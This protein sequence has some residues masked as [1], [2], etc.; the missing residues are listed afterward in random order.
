MIQKKFSA[1]ELEKI[2]NDYKLLSLP[3]GERGILGKATREGW[4]YEQVPSK[5]GKGG[6]KKVFLLPNDVVDEIREKGLMHL[7][8]EAVSEQL[9]PPL[10]GDISEP[11]KPSLEYGNLPSF[12]R[13]A[14]ANYA[15]WAMVQ[16]IDDIIPI[17]Y[18]SNVYGS[19]GNG[20]IFNDILETEAM[21]FRASF[22]KRLGV[23][24]ERCFCTRVKGDSMMP[25]LI[26][27]GTVLWHGDNRYTGEG[28]YLFRYLDELKIKRLQRIG[29]NIYRIISDNPNQIT[30]P[31]TDLDLSNAQEYDFEIYGKY[32]WD[33]GISE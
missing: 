30:Y 24:P 14:V 29:K 8:G 19:A 7:M 1:K 9:Q 22:F 10:Q 2:V 20:F 13:R 12:M 21:W 23:R 16:K 32:L 4:E 26:D 33:C 11:T 18:Y 15:D 27:R 6:K 25:T 28:I 31:V 17:R 5:G 3:G